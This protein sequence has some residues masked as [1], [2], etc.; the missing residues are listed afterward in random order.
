M[1]DLYEGEENSSSQ[2]IQR[3]NREGNTYT[4]EKMEE[5]NGGVQWEPWE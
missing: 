3:I 4:Y 1:R 2:C 5:S